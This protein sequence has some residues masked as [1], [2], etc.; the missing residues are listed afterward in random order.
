V[1]DF[2]GGWSPCGP[3]RWPVLDGDEGCPACGCIVG[4]EPEPEPH[5][6]RWARA[7]LETRQAIADVDAGTD[8]EWRAAA[9]AVVRTVCLEREEFISDDIWKTGLDS[10]REDRALGPV[11]LK[12]RRL[13]WCEKTGRVQPSVRS[14]LSGKPVWRSLLGK[15]S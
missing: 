13:G 9:L 6:E 5:D 10:T 14:H 1:S 3:C 7:E 8:A 12:A 11:M 2:N 4:A 15:A